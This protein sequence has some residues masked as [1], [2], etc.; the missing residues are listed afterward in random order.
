MFSDYTDVC[1]VKL[2]PPGARPS[3]GPLLTAMSTD[4]PSLRMGL[5]HILEVR[6]Y[7]SVENG[8]CRLVTGKRCLSYFE[9][10]HV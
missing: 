3:L 4:N 9:H 2:Q 10:R 6:P 1:S 7:T 8:M 5:V